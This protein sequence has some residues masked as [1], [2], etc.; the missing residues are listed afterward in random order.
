MLKE[1]LVS[2]SCKHA[3]TTEGPQTGHF[4]G[5]PTDNVTVIIIG[6]N[7]FVC[8]CASAVYI[9]YVPLFEEAPYFQCNNIMHI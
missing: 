9:G 6:Y 4:I 5:T 3:C 7:V 1:L 2:S 8:Q